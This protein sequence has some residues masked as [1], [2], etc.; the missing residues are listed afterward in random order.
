VP[1]CPTC[2]RFLSPPSVTAEGACPACGRPVEAG[3][4]RPPGGTTDTDAPPV[5]GEEEL[6]PV[7][8]HMKILG[9]S[10]V[11]YLGYRFIQGVDWVIHRF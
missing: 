10:V 1:W 4:A 2:D 9:A 11:I 6:P 3:R 8:V 5:G 7:P